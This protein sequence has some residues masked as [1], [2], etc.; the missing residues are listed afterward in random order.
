MI[1]ILLLNILLKIQNN[2]NNNQPKLEAP[3]I[4]KYLIY[5]NNCFQETFK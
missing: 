1:L 4:Y 5:S 2:L 3:K